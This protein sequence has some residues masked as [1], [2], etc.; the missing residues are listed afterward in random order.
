MYA[1]MTTENECISGRVT[2]IRI[3]MK[4]KEMNILQ[5]YATQTGCSKED[6]E[7]FKK[8]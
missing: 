4:E 3:P 7:E 2:K 5:I 8:S 1:E 6:Y